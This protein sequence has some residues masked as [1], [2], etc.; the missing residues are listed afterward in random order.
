M[1]LRL[2]RGRGT[3]LPP[4]PLGKFRFQFDMPFA[5]CSRHVKIDPPSRYSEEGVSHTGVSSSLSSREVLG[6]IGRSVYP[7][8]Q[9]TFPSLSLRKHLLL[10]RI[11][12][13]LAVTQKTT[14]AAISPATISLEVYLREQVQRS[15]HQAVPAF[16]QIADL[17]TSCGIIG[18]RAARTELPENRLADHSGAPHDIDGIDVR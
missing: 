5:S 14:V 1:R 18:R 11:T 7:I 4:C 13:M 8:P 9:L 17:I 15:Q 3:V 6:T 10:R 16:L 2:L 12:A